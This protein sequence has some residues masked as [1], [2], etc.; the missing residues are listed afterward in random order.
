EKMRGEPQLFTHVRQPDGGPF[1]DRNGLLFLSPEELE[2]VAQQLIAAQPLMGS[3]AHDPSLRGL[4]DAL[5]TFV[6]GAGSDASAV[7]QLDPTLATIANVV[8][9]VVEGRRASLSW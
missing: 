1:F 4:F 3:L 9:R 6:S 2:K 8:Q 5:A 7:A